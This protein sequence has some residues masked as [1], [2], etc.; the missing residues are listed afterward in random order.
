MRVPL[1]ILILEDLPDDA[2]LIVHELRRVGYDPEWLRVEN[3]KDFLANIDPSLDVIIA[4]YRLPDFDALRALELLQ[5]HGRDIPLIVVTGALGDETAVECLNRGAADYLLKD[6]LARL[7]QAVTQ[8]IKARKFR[9]EKMISSQI[10]RK[11]EKKFRSIFENAE[12]GIFQTSPDGEFLVANPTGARIL[13][14]DSPEDLVDNLVDVQNRFHVDPERRADLKRI[15]DTERSVRGF[16]T[17]VYQKDGSIIWVSISARS[18]RDLRGDITHYESTL[19]DISQRKQ[20]EERIREQANL[21]NLAHDAIVV[22]DMDETIRFWNKGAE[23]L[24][25]ITADS[26]IGKKLTSQIYKDK[27]A[28]FTAQEELLKSGDWQG[29]LRLSPRDSAEKIVNSRW[30]LVRDDDDSPKSILV[31]DIDITEKKEMERQILRSQR[32]ESIGTLAS[33]IAHDLNNV[34]TPILAS[35]ALLRANR[36]KEAFERTLGTI[37]SSAMRGAEIVKQVLTF[38]RGVDGDRKPTALHPLIDE[39]IKISR[40]TFPKSIVIREHLSNETWPVI[41]DTTQIEQMLLNL[42]INARDAMP[43][44][45]AITIGARNVELGPTEMGLNT[46]T[47]PGPYV[48]LYVEDSGTGIPAAIVDKIF[49]PFFT[50]KQPGHGTGLG[51]SS[52]VGILKGHG[53]AVK[54]DSA[55]NEGSTFRLYLPAQ[56]DACTKSGS[57]SIDRVEVGAGGLILIVDDEPSVREITQTILEAAGYE[58]IVTCDGEEALELYRDKNQHITA[59]LTD[60]LMPS[61]DGRE[62]IRAIF[63]INPEARVMAFSG[64]ISESTQFGKVNELRQLGV[65][66]FLQKPFKAE[67]L[68]QSLEDTLN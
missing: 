9:E 30:T 10:I 45:G 61:M 1:K 56:P 26:V 64:F 32:M 63:E 38:A 17:Q 33:G 39:V 68:L 31:I 55:L 59:V 15:L 57:K 6:R 18:M 46:D 58:V 14:F 62:L 16:E 11:A 28:V 12:E 19:Q 22:R 49:D 40:K 2:E 51:L 37:E 24:Y 23:N 20:A 27:V 7:G 65:R 35:T 3:E 50:T 21:L 34:L 8:A 29:E 44:G 47:K 52:L 36:S 13:G 42:C 41:G 66:S 4:D 25:G 48:E 43:N 5:K 60:L 54:V 53:G 67:N